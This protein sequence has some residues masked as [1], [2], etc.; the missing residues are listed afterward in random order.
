M[1]EY[2]KNNKKYWVPPILIFI[3]VLIFIASQAADTP[4]SPFEYRLR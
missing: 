4:E 2:L 3:A 1:I